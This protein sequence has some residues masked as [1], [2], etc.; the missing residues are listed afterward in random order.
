MEQ[1]DPKYERK[2]KQLVAWRCEIADAGLQFLHLVPTFILSFEL[3]VR[4]M[5]LSR[6]QS[7]HFYS[8]FAYIVLTSAYFV[9]H[10]RSP[11]PL[12]SSRY[13]WAM[14]KKS[15]PAANPCWTLR[16]CEQRYIWGSYL[17]VTDL[18]LEC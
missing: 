2:R 10:E 3:I 9:E 4:P 7:L 12:T 1:V 16:W 11:F 17:I 15:P 14:D 18:F 13:T 6:V 5:T 8:D